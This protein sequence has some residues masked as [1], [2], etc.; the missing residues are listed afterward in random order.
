MLHK[1]QE[2]IKYYPWIDRSS[3]K[4]IMNNPLN[5]GFGKQEV[6]GEAE[7][8]ADKLELNSRLIDRME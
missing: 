1:N 8:I 4:M 5:Y 7:R 3:N 6:Q 2:E